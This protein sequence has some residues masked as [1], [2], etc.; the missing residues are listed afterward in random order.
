MNKN[1]FLEN[2]ARNLYGLPQEEIQKSL[3]FYSEMIDDR[4]EDGMTEEE[5]VAALGNPEDIAREIFLEQ[6][7]PVILKSKNRGKRKFHTW[8]IV[9]LIA[10]SPVWFPLLIA[11]LAVVFSVYIVIWAILLVFWAVNI[12]LAI[13]FPAGI[14]E[15]VLRIFSGNTPAALFMAGAG[16]VCGGLAVFWFFGT[17]SLS[18]QLIR[19]TGRFSRWI[20]GW[21][22]RKETAL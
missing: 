22:L 17:K 6:S 9:L 18:R 21:F 3:E 11:F 5:A 12:S 15:C 1:D 10:G 19:L 14:L 16:L 8:E 13:G 4:I 2:L 7:L 20:K